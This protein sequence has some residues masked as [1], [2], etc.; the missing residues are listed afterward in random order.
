VNVQARGIVARGVE[1]MQNEVASGT[2]CTTG[3]IA[4]FVMALCAHYV[5]AADKSGV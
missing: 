1:L 2:E 5:K 4:N 3:A